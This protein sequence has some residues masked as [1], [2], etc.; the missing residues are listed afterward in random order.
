MEEIL[1]S[2]INGNIVMNVKINI[3]MKNGKI[4]RVKL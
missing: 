4:S 3:M 1:H 2:V